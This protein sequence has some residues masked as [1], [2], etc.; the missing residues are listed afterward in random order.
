MTDNFNKALPYLKSLSVLEL[1]RVHR[2]TLHKLYDLK[3]VRTLNAPQA[4]WAE[5]LVAKA[6]RGK[7]AESSAKGYDIIA[8]DQSLLQVKS[9]V[10]G[11]RKRRWSNSS[12]FR[13]EKFNK[14]VVVIFDA[15]DLSVRRAAE[16]S[17][18]EIQHNLR[19]QE[20]VNGSRLV[21]RDSLMD[22][23]VD[24]TARLQ[25]AAK[26]IDRETDVALCER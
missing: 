10:I 18:D 3:V 5:R 11:K 12:S 21:I 24:V 26:A 9:T 25:Q 4:D 8:S 20:Y 16:F 14:L 7:R 17:R 15:E 6:Y 22:A 19:Y 23:G 2:W 13:S 1:L